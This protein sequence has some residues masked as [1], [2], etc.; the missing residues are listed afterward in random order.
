MEI[1]KEKNPILWLRHLLPWSNLKKDGESTPSVVSNQDDY[2]MWCSN[3]S[4]RDFSIKQK[5]LLPKS[6]D[7]GFARSEV[8][9][10]VVKWLIL[11]VA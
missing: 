7:T 10:W 2:K 3:D 9:Y 5:T 6:E 11:K 8:F 4:R 1:G